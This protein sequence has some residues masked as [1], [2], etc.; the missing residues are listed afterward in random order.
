M[1]IFLIKNREQNAK[2]FISSATQIAIHEFLVITI[3]EDPIRNV[4]NMGEYEIL[5]SHNGH[6]IAN[7][8]LF[9]VFFKPYV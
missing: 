9:Q 2:V 5:F 4:R 7:L 1:Y 3:R 8:E 6:Q